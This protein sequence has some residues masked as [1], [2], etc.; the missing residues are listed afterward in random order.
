[1]VFIHNTS[2]KAMY[3]YLSKCYLSG[4]YITFMKLLINDILT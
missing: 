3:L 4:N 2:I 1:M